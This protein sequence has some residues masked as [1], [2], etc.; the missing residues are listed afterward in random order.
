MVTSEQNPDVFALQSVIESR[1]LLVHPQPGVYMWQAAVHNHNI[2]VHNPTL[3][4]I[5]AASGAGLHDA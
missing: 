2:E 4:L 5:I 1:Q 3:F